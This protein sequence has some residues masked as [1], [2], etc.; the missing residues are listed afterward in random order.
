MVSNNTIH[1]L[2]YYKSIMTDKM[3]LQWKKNFTYMADKARKAG[4]YMD[5]DTVSM[6]ERDMQFLRYKLEVLEPFSRYLEVFQELGIPLPK[7]PFD[8]YPEA[9]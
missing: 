4:E 3:I 7:N 9:R 6:A 5:S 8:G 1:D 2:D